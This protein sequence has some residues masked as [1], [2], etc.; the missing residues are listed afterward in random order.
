MKNL[1]NIIFLSLLVSCTSTQISKEEFKIREKIS[2]ASLPEEYREYKDKPVTGAGWLKS[3]DGKISAYKEYDINLDN[4][5][6]VIEI[7]DGN[8]KVVAYSFD[9]DKNGNFD[10]YEVL[11]DDKADG[12]NGN[13][14]PI[15]INCN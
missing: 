3:P 9:L 12:L 5:S 7:Y 13:E 11:T 14:K 4:V 1:L 15:A 6:D 2:Y 10:C 8:K